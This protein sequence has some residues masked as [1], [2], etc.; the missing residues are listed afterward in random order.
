M[1]SD[2]Y[3]AARVTYSNDVVI[4]VRRGDND[5]PLLTLSLDEADDLAEQLTTILT[6]LK[7]RLPPE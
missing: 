2:V 5:T 3:A 7:I 6:L 1:D 4:D